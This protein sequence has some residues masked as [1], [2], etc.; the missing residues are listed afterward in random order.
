MISLPSVLVKHP[1]VDGLHYI[2]NNGP[3]L[4]FNP[5]STAW[6]VSRLCYVISELCLAAFGWFWKE[7]LLVSSIISL[8]KLVSYGE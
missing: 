3:M 6:I 1:S 7:T 8:K 5:A 4:G 2:C